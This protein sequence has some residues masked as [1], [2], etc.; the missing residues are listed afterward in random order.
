L[1][2]FTKAVR[3]RGE[4]SEKQIITSQMVQSNF[5]RAK[6]SK[7]MAYY[8]VFREIMRNFAAKETK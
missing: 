5:D 2:T 6:V 8:K 3:G 7:K 4:F 1:E